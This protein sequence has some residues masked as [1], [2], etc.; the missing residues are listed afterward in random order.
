MTF[1]HNCSFILVITEKY[2]HIYS[3]LYVHILMGFNANV[4]CLSDIFNSSVKGFSVIL[5]VCKR[6]MV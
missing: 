6:M 3:S 4:I 2:Q 5:S 1:N